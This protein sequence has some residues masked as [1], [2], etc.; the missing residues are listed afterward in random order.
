MLETIGI[1]IVDSS[2]E[3][4]FEKPNF[5]TEEDYNSAWVQYTRNLSKDKKWFTADPILEEVTNT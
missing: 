4:V 5:P 3:H 1:R 2:G